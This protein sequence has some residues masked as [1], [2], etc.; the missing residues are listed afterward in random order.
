[1]NNSLILPAITPHSSINWKLSFLNPPS[2][3]FAQNDWAWGGLGALLMSSFC[4][5]KWRPEG[6]YEPH[7]TSHLLMGSVVTSDAYSWTLSFALTY[8]PTSHS[9]PLAPDLKFVV[10]VTG[11]RKNLS[12]W[13]RQEA[14]QETWPQTKLMIS[15]S[16]ALCCALAW[17]RQA[18]SWG[19]K[20][21]MC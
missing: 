18:A 19:R 11:K 8:K 15:V 20:V 1:M 12:S 9:L 5:R 3:R 21:D 17:V 4:R 10:S 7:W 16:P 2:R 6:L 13:L 14:E